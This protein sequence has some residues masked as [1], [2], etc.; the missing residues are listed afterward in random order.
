MNLKR[1]SIW[2]FDL[3]SNEFSIHPVDDA[4]VDQVISNGITV[5]Y[6]MTFWDKGHQIGGGELGCQRFKEDRRTRKRRSSSAR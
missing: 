6:V 2:P 1:H 3:T 4:W 5:T